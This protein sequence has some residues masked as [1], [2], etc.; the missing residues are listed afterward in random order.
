MQAWIDL[1]TSNPLPC[2]GIIIGLGAFVWG[3]ARLARGKDMH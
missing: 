2:T 3:V 1:L